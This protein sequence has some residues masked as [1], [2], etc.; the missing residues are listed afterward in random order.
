[1]NYFKN[2]TYDIF[3]HCND[4]IAM[5]ISKEGYLKNNAFNLNKCYL[6]VS[7]VFY[8]GSIKKFDF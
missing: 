4:V 3:E 1:M 6:Y 2:S 8:F 5:N 7:N